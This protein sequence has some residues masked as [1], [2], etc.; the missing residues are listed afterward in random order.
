MRRK[1]ERFRT[2]EREKKKKVE[3]R[4]RNCEWR[5]ESLRPVLS[6]FHHPRALQGPFPY[7]A[8]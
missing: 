3:E 2:C 8:R 4:F 7:H 1:K 6:S 5:K